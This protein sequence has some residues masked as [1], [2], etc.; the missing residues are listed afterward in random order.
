MDDVTD[1]NINNDKISAILDS[2]RLTR[3]FD[4]ELGFVLSCMQMNCL[5]CKTEQSMIML[6]SDK[7]KLDADNFYC[8][9]CDIGTSNT[10]SMKR[11]IEDFREDRNSLLKFP[12]ETFG[13]R[14]E[15]MRE[16]QPNI[17]Q[18]VHELIKA[19]EAG[20]SIFIS[21]ANNMRHTKTYKAYSKSLG[22][23]NRLFMT[24]SSYF[25]R[26]EHRFEGKNKDEQLD[27]FVKLVKQDQV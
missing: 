9:A 2:A 11:Y 8:H 3:V 7:G 15:E 19:V 22:D 13:A 25:E 14:I 1:K 26:F 20:D 17:V 12:D 5:V 21:L 16:Y 18:M 24:I 10:N 4:E 23:K 27:E 6:L